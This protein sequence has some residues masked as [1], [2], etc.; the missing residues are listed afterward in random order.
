MSLR[1]ALD[2]LARSARSRRPADLQLVID[3]ALAGLDRSGIA[4]SCLQVGEVAPDFELEAIDGKR[5]TLEAALRAGPVVLTFYRGGWCPYCNLALR[6]MN[7]VLPALRDLGAAVFAIAPQRVTAMRETGDKHGLG[8]ALLSDPGN[9][10]G[11]LFGLTYRLPPPLVALYRGL[12]IDLPAANGTADWELPLPATYVVGRDGT[13]A[14]AFID[15]D[16]T[17]RAE[18]EEIIAAVRRMTE[19]PV[20]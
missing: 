15:V 8:F 17:K 18:P 14:H 10:V 2:D 5:V 4:R 19:E 16:Y 12:G 1:E 9:R 11:R 20:K 6:A 7:Q 3:T 13:V